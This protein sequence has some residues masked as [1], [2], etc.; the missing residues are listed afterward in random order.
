[1]QRRSDNHAPNINVR[2]ESVFSKLAFIGTCC[3]LL[4]LSPLSRIVL[5]IGALTLSITS[6]VLLNADS[7]NINGPQLSDLL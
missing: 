7:A 3:T 1:M 4:R 5:V 6:E 2:A